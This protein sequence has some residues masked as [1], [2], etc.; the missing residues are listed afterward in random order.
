MG[1]EGEHRV[2]AIVWIVVLCATIL[3]I[4]ILT[5][6]TP[7]KQSLSTAPQTNSIIADSLSA[8]SIGFKP[9]DPNTA[10]YRTMIEA[11]VPRDIVVSL[12]KWRG[13]GKVFRIKEEVA[14][15]YNM[16][17]SIYFALEP[18]I[19]IGEEY[20]IKPSSEAI[21]EY[22]TTAKREIEYTPFRIDTATAEYLRTLGF[23]SR[24]AELV[25]RY[26]DMI[27]GYRNMAEFKECYAVDSMMASR[28]QPYII[29]EERD[30]TLA[31][32]RSA[33]AEFKLPI[34]INSADSAT[35]VRVQGIGPKSAQ[36]IL[37]YRELL[38][39]YYSKS[40]ISELE[41][42]TEENF[43]KILP[44]IWCDSAKIKKIF[45]NFARSNELEVHPYIS[46]RML[47]RIVNYR[48]LKGGWSTIEEMIESDI[49]SVDEAAR[50]APY[51]D[52]GTNHQVD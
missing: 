8:E 24:Q 35:L 42:V 39:G 5:R 38:G 14:L 7:Q 45:I 21:K 51:L 36:H 34:D 47:K 22:P 52:F 49:F 29:F 48:E 37:R 41:V 46:N 17:D 4:S 20:R 32:E 26:R 13:A 33:Y 18:Y 43:H 25:I 19:T 23:S 27:G 1:R 9:F 10:D 3:V 31:T 16:T 15:C 2:S 30:T 44:Q 6:P 11:G 12:I 50:I 40:Q 28:L